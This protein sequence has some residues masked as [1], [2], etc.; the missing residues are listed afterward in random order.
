MA[1]S[2][3]VEVKVGGKQYTVDLRDPELGALVGIE[4]IFG[5]PYHQISDD[6]W[7]TATGTVALV[8]LAKRQDDPGFSVE[9]ATRLRLGEIEFSASS[10]GSDPTPAAKRGK[11]RSTRAASGSQS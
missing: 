1:E 4:R 8:F 2:G 6:E 11:R 9:D 3:T 5:K 10:N 7:N